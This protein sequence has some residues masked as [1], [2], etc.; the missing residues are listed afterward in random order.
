MRG[1]ISMTNQRR[2][3]L[4][5]AIAFAMT[6]AVASAWAEDAVGTAPA[7]AVSGSVDPRDQKLVDMQ[8]MLQN[9]A[10]EVK[11][12]RAQRAADVQKVEAV[13]AA[14]S[15]FPKVAWKGAPEFSGPGGATFK[16]RG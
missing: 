3:M 4:G 8:I 2:L 6:G 15:S 5:G 16:V 11:E 1:P 12:L 13:A 10:E 9:L 14:Q 7:D